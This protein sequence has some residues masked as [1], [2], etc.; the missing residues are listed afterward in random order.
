MRGGNEKGVGVLT[1]NLPYCR[2]PLPLVAGGTLPSAPYNASLNRAEKKMLA[3]ITVARFSRARAEGKGKARAIREKI[4]GDDSPHLAPLHVS[5][6][7]E[8]SY[9]PHCVSKAPPEGDKSS[10]IMA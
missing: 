3:C 8:P 10:S 1:F 4:R 2:S 5:L 7:I 6:S 9:S